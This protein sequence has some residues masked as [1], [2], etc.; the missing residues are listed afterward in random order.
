MGIFSVGVDIVE[1]KRVGKLWRDG[2]IKERCYTEGERRYIEGFEEPDERAAGFFCAKEAVLKAL[3]PRLS[4]RDIEVCHEPS[5]RPYITLHNEA[6]DMA[7][8]EGLTLHLSISHCKEYA[9]A[10]VIAE[11]RG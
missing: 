9:T 6:L 3:S 5:G 7:K 1:T 2:A 11:R 10:T 8:R 4:L